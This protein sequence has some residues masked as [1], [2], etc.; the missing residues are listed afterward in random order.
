MLNIVTNNVPRDVLSG[1]E[2]DPQILRDEFDIEVQGMNDD[3]IGD[4]CSK[5]FVKFRGV[6]MIW[7]ILSRLVPVLG[8]MDCLKSSRSGMGILLIVSFLVSS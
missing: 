8:T 3:Q 4:L 2:M 1:Y 6:C 5:E 7:K